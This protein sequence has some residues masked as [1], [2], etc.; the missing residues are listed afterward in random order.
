MRLFEVL[1]TSYNRF[2]ETIRAYLS[3]AL[4]SI[5]ENYSK[6][7]IYGVIFEGVRGIMQ[8]AMFYLEDALT[9]QNIY[10]A[11]RKK[12]IYS[13]AKVSGYEAYYGSAATGTI[14]GVL[15]I[16]NGIVGSISTKLTM[17]NYSQVIDKNT[18]ITYMIMLDTNK[19]I[20]DVNSPLVTYEFKIVQGNFINTQYTARGE[21]LE[22]ISVDIDS[23]FDREYVS[24][25]VNGERWQCVS[26][27]YDMSNESKECIFTVGYENSFDIIFGNG[28]YGKIP[29]Y[30][31]TIEI[32]FIAHIGSRG[33]ISSP[34]NSKFEFIT[35]GYDSYGNDVDLNKYMKLYLTNVV[36][37]GT[38]A[39][40]IDFVRS[41]IG[42]NS[43]SNVL[44]SEENFLLFFKRFSFIGQVNCW[45]EHNTM[46][47]M[48][49]CTSN[50]IENIKEID[51][52]FDLKDEDFLLTDKQKDMIINTLDNSK[53]AF[54]GLT[55]KFQDPVIRKFALFCYIK[56]SSAYAKKTVEQDVRHILGKY[57]MNLKENT[58]FIPK[59]D[60]V[61]LGSTCN[62]NIE[63]FDIDIISETNE[64]A[65]ANGGYYYKYE[66]RKA[67]DTYIYEK[68]KTFCES[69]KTPGL[70]L[71][72]N[73]QLDSKLEIPVLH[74]FYYYADKDHMNRRNMI[75]AINF[76]FI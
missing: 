18:G 75:D 16:N 66:L 50:V 9:E 72:G 71:A 31:S 11:S 76:F 3:K 61:N 67:N 64:T 27:L 24:V 1:A 48:T 25:Y 8:N 74:G 68:V 32:K 63:S 13:L 57:F 58:Q 41:M 73:I 51:E 10:T 7:Q 70:D 44:A 28:T 29:E 65:H 46:T 52:Y 40:T 21:A 14:K 39:D 33:N 34:L 37:G 30:G 20:I 15:H 59:S 43:R 12:S 55:L 54:A 26:S 69:E 5:G 4:G 42:Y 47:I 23:L 22:R 35:N 53:K 45:S 60:L 17:M 49:T 62:E 2:D 6:N 56:C 38:D 19:Y 36:S